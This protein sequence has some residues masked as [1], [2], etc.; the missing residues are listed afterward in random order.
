MDNF[1]L[2]RDLKS[3]I[4]NSVAELRVILKNAAKLIKK[5]KQNS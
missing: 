3:L 4:Y 2:L 5:G 1:L